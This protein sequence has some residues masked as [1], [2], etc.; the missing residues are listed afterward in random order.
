[1][2]EKTGLGDLVARQRAFFDSGATRPAAFRREQLRKLLRAIL[3]SER[4]I[5][6]AVRADLGKGDFEAFTTELYFTIHEIKGMIR[7]V[8][9]WTNSERRPTGV[10]NFPGSARVI[11]DPHGVC[12]VMSPWNYPFMLSLMPVVGAIAGGNTVILKPSA[13]S[14]ATSRAIAALLRE[15][16]SDNY[17]ACVEGGRE[18]NQGLLAERFDYIFF[19][20]SVAVGKTVM[21]AA[22]RHL[23]PV[24]LELGGKSPCIVDRSAN[25]ELAARRA[26]WGKCI[27]AGQ[28]CVAPDYFLVHESVRDEFIAAF[29]RA[30]A[31][32]YG[33]RPLESP[34]LPRIV[35]QKHFERL[36]ALIEGAGPKLVFGGETDAKSLKIEP[37]VLANVSWEDPVMREEI[38]G[39]I[40]P[41]IAWSD[42]DEILRK[43]LGRPRPLALYLFTSDRGQER[44]ILGRVPFGGGCVNDVVMHL[45]SAE[46][47]FGGTGESGMGA[48][49]GRASFETFTRMKS[50]MRK[51]TLVDV[52]VRYPPYGK[53]YRRLRPFL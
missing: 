48:Y 20:G 14:P 17:V 53:K 1:M 40:A 24:T 21:E 26:A 18:V 19:T 10:F 41:V 45:A 7:R 38:F 23:T 5:L 30:V 28:T 11:R 8:G 4:T 36:A 52:P 42:E 35:S 46:L 43:I 32:F 2:S 6:D 39:P 49:H 15:T 44:R 3:A 33:E 12:L 37:T 25:V 51:S 50:V 34:D 47:P 9:R 22:S 29:E 27:N 16:F 31:S 13:Y